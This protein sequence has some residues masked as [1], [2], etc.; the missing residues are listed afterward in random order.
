[1][2]MRYLKFSVLVSTAFSQYAPESPKS[3]NLARELAGDFPVMAYI[4]EDGN[5]L[6]ASPPAY[7]QGSFLQVCVKIDDAVVTNNI[8]VEDILTF[9]VSQ[10]NNTLS[11]DSESITNT[12]ANLSTNKVCRES[13]ICNVKT[14]LL[15]QFFTEAIPGDLR[16]DGVAILAFGQASPIPSLAPSA[17][18][19]GR[20]LR[21]VPIRGLITGDDVKVLLAAQQKKLNKDELGV[22][23]I[24]DSSQRMLQDGSNQSDFG[25]EVGLNGVSGDEGSS[26]GGVSAVVVAVIVLHLLAA[27]CGLLFF[28][29]IRKRLKEDPKDIVDHDSSNTGITTYPSQASVYTSSPSQNVSHLP[30][31]SKTTITTE[32]SSVFPWFHFQKKPQG[33]DKGVADHLESNAGGSTDP[34]QAS[35]YSSSSRH[36]VRDCEQID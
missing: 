22:S 1:M 19:I 28:C 27:G 18:P 7:T 15:A 25:L 8:R 10:P 29:C 34:G 13:G 2:F 31:K 9:V 5:T 17:A 4:C 20:R 16:V 11:S 3:N 24:I 36:H 14:Q 30:T 33:G 26:G 32:T 21:A 23:V 35:V 6:V 12:V